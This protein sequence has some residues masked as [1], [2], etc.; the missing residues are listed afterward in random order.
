LNKFWEI[1]QSEFVH[2]SGW[3]TAF[4][5]DMMTVDET[6]RDDCRLESLYHLLISDYQ[7]AKTQIWQACSEWHQANKFAL[8]DRLIE[9][10]KEHM[11]GGRLPQE[12]EEWLYGRTGLMSA[13][14]MGFYPLEDVGLFANRYEL[15][16]EV[17]S[18]GV[19][20][21]FYAFD[22]E[23]NAHVA[24]RLLHPKFYDDET[25]VSFLDHAASAQKV[26]EVPNIQRI[27]EHRADPDV[28]YFIAAQYIHG[29]TLDEII[30]EEGAIEPQKAEQWALQIAKA[31]S[32]AHEAKVIH[33]D[34]K[35]SNIFISDF[36]RVV[37]ADFSFGLSRSIY[38]ENE[39]SVR[40]AIMFLGTYGYQAP[41]I[42]EG[43]DITPA[44][45]I[46]SFGKVLFDLLAGS[47]SSENPQELSVRYVFERLLD[48]RYSEVIALQISSLIGRCLSSVIDLRPNAD[49][50]IDLLLDIEW[51]QV[52][53]D[54]TNLGTIRL[55]VLKPANA[56]TS[57]ADTAPE[58]TMGEGAVSWTGSVLQRS[59]VDGVSTDRDQAE[60]TSPD[61]D[62]TDN[63]TFPRVSLRSVGGG[64]HLPTEFVL[65]QG[66]T[67]RIGRRPAYCD[68]VIEDKRVSRIHASITSKSTGE[69]Y[70]KD[71]GSS[72]GT[73]VNRRKLRINRD[74]KLETGDIINFN[75]VAYVFE[76][77]E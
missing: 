27:F 11:N 32:D 61:P 25:I 45:D 8:L 28:G 67:Y 39:T 2:L 31:L 70:I 58:G 35:P 62:D 5:A 44:S 49:E 17:G 20:R 15:V 34:L 41:E 56:N 10:I 53:R 63:A 43:Q 37:V 48:L 69:W 68:L 66:R 71:E 30:H 55:P 38:R 52:R 23:M 46:Y 76:E 64:E 54:S 36:S 1:D 19:F 9:F 60:D 77:A 57:E 24:L 47:S 6:T 74:E 40:S 4:F 42:F 12:S 26:L 22:R 7:H 72:G 73:Y 51:S 29:K 33:G 59:Q 75:A 13:I 14:R 50:L 16:K 65:L 3:A 21:V 18:G